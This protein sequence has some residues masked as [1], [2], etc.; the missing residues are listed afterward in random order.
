MLF[1]K[2]SMGK[3]ALFLIV[4]LFLIIP[5]VS[6]S[7]FP[8]LGDSG[9]L[10]LGTSER[11]LCMQLVQVCENCTYVNVTNVLNPN[12]TFSLLG[13]YATS[14]NDTTY[15]LT[16]CSTGDLGDYFY[17]SCGDLDGLTECKTSR[18]TITKTGRTS[19]VSEAIIYII[20][21]IGGLLLF[22]M[23]LFIAI[24]TPWRNKRS[25]HGKI[26]SVNKLKYVKLGFILLCYPLFVWILNLLLG[27]SDYLYLSM[28]EGLFSFMFS[29]MIY[30]QWPLAF[31]WALIFIKVV[32]DDSRI[33]KLMKRGF[34]KIYK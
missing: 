3:E 6:A 12:K 9:D 26:I 10:F 24:I 28:Y 27:L 23:S 16:Y 21:F 34:T 20:S 22:G 32:I 33:V 19:S 14:K 17:T 2:R 8:N 15:N 11:D 31:I 7:E 29:V 13:Q 25:E 1:F 5:V 4:V 18:F 30:L